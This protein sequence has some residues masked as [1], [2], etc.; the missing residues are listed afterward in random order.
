MKEN[1]RKR[2]TSEMKNTLDRQVEFHTY[3]NKEKN[4]FNPEENSY[5]ALGGLFK[6]KPASYDK[7]AYSEYLKKQAEEQTN[8]KKKDQL[9][10]EEEYLIN[11]NQLNVLP[12]LSLE[13]SEW[14][15]C[16]R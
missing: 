15:L 4:R 8:R 11:M 2:L 12:S 10:S 1:E 3:V 5:R 6:D 9:M 7:R 14:Q 16:L 13:S